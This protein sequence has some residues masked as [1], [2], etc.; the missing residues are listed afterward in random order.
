MKPAHYGI[1]ICVLLSCSPP[2]TETDAGPLE[3]DAGQVDA[4]SGDAGT[5]PVSA[6]LQ[7]HVGSVVSS[8][9]TDPMRCANAVAVVVTP[10]E[11]RVVGF[12][13]RSAS[14]P[15]PPDEH[16]V[17]QLGSVTKLLTGLALA[18]LVTTGGAQPGDAVPSHLKSDLSGALLPR[19][20]SLL[21]LTTHTAGFP[22]MP[23][24]LRR[25]PDGGIDPSSP[26]GGYDRADL[27]AYLQGWTPLDGGYRYSNLGTG[28][29]AIALED[30][31]DAGSYEGAL[32]SLVTGPLGLEDTFGQVAALDADAGARLVEGHASRQ[33][34]WWPARPAEMGVLA[35]GGEALTTGADLARL[36]AALSGVERGP[37]EDAVA[38]AFTPVVEL[39][40]TQHIGYGVVVEH[41]DG[42][43]VFLKA[44][45]TPSFSAF[46]VA[47]RAPS[48]LGVAVVAGCGQP[49]PV[50][51][52]ALRLFDALRALR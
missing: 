34:R 43:D 13:A 27:A 16:S 52:V 32:R 17:F 20:P 15:R 12:G 7:Q 40:A 5:S 3:P 51:E 30:S 31:L 45:N 8:A 47:Q 14:D 18:R 33:G 48:P 41:R 49:F 46:I 6:L 37:L 2:A 9:P 10:V 29:L 24:N 21:A 11:R 50:D 26:A 42:G 25:L 28:L 4:G 22:S 1:A 23:D 35:G 39:S 44:G 19:G 38:L 36:L